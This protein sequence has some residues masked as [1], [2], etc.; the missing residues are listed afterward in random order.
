[1]GDVI[2]IHSA[3][4]AG[5]YKSGR[6]SSR[7]TPVSRSISKTNSAGTP[8]FDFLSQYQTCDW[9]VPMRAAKG[10]CPPASSQ[11]RDSASVDI[12]PPYSHLGTGQPKNL[13]VQGY[14]DLGNVTFMP[15]PD[16]IAFG[17]RVRERREE[18]DL[19]QKQLGMACGYSQ[20]NIRTFESGTVKRPERCAPALA[21]AL[22]T[23]MDWLLWK[24][25]PKLAGPQFMSD[26]QLVEKF[27]QLSPEIKEAISKA[28]DEA[29][30]KRGRKNEPA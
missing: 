29:T 10:F 22:R 28:I 6:N 21:K 7:G 16:S 2:T 9:V 20:Q 18:L 13:S 23:T 30:K 8:R 24:K 5:G 27:G 11:A 26:K 3:A 12:G 19:S 17:Q 25:G 4:S 1:M 14:R 15:K